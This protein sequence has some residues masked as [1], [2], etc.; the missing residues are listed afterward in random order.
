[1][2]SHLSAIVAGAGL[3][4]LFAIPVAAQDPVWPG[5][6]WAVATPESQGIRSA[7]FAVLDSEIAKGQFG[8]VDRFLVISNGYKIVDHAYERD[9]NVL[10]HGKRDALGCGFDSCEA[11]DDFGM[12]NYYD[13]LTHPF[14]M[15]GELHSLQSVTKSITVSL[16]G[17]ALGRGE[18]SSRQ[19]S[20][21]SFFEGYDLQNTDP[22]LFD[23][24]LNHILTMRLGLAWRS[25]GAM[26]HSSTLSLEHSGDWIQYI[27]SHP[28]D[29]SPGNKWLYSDGASHLMSGII[30]SATGKFADEYA[31]EFLFGPIGI[32][33]YYWKKT[34]NGYPDTEG[35]LY[36]SAE[37]L[38]RFGYLYLNDG[39]WAGERVLPAGWAGLATHRHVELDNA[40]NTAYGL[41]WWR[42]DRD[43]TVV[44]AGRG[45]GGQ[46]VL[47]MPDHGLVGV[48]NGWN[49]VGTPTE[50]SI[51]S[52]LVDAM[53]AAVAE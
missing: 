26:E 33:D 22:R 20:V 19:A 42:I 41:Q 52:A 48:T 51:E 4:L 25:V 32:D 47:I 10:S 34:V 43:D 30:K 36:L 11:G 28:M 18:I 15:G 14:F 21:L 7:P 46:F 29:S 50:S 1:M 39:M 2:F 6:D 12:Y 24:K 45:F 8:A 13:P 9:Y 38:A 31:E 44:W 16:I 27:L 35:G 3:A 49:I 17:I 40:A 37:D 23:A 5:E 53:I